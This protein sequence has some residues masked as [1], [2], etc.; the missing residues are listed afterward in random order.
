VT[1]LCAKLSS[2]DPAVAAAARSEAVAAALAASKSGLARE[3]HTIIPVVLARLS[4]VL[5]K[6]LKP[7]EAFLR[8]LRPAAELPA[9]QV[10]PR[11]CHVLPKL[12]ASHKLLQGTTSKH[13]H[14]CLS[15]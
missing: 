2:Q 9:V 6:G 10:G 3:L 14:T 8:C 4:A 12:L 1:P 5:R 11:S 7:A 13:L 15:R